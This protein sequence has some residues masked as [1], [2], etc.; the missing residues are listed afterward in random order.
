VWEKDFLR[1]RPD[2]SSVRKERGLRVVRGGE[3]V[4][5]SFEA[6][7]TE[8]RAKRGI[9]FS[10]DTARHGKCFGEVFSHSRLLRALAWEEEND[11]HR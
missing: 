8:L 4:G 11:I 10:E 2:R 3:L 7:V 9:D 1:N 5:W 6:E